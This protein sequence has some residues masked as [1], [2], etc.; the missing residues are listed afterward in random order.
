M[1]MTVTTF[2]NENDHKTNNNNDGSDNAG[3]ILTWQRR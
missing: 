3:K 2:V 1:V